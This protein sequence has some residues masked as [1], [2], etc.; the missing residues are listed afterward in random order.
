MV[1]PDDAAVGVSIVTVMWQV[2]FV[3]PNLR[4]E[5]AFEGD[6]IAI[7]PSTDT[8]VQNRARENQATSQLI[9]G[10]TD[11]FGNRVQVSVIVVRHDA[12]AIAKTLEALISF[13]N[14]FAIACI[15]NGWQWQIGNP[16][17]FL[18]LYSDFFDCYPWAPG[19][20]KGDEIVLIG[21]AL[22]SIRKAKNFSG[23]ISPDVPVMDAF[24]KANPDQAILAGLQARWR[25]RFGYSGRKEWQTTALF[26]SLAIAYQASALP[27][28]NSSTIFDYGTAI[29]LWVSAFEALLH[30]KS[31]KITLEAILKFF[32][33]SQWIDKSLTHRKFK[34][35][36]LSSS[37]KKTER[38]NRVKAFYVQLYKARNDFLHGNPVRV[39]KLLL[40]R[41]RKLVDLTKVAP[42]LYAV[43]LHCFLE[44][45]KQIKGKNLVVRA[46]RKVSQRS[47]LERALLG[48]TIPLQ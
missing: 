40:N 11:Q 42:L 33:K 6:F 22:E 44:T 32:D 29:S 30:P 45:V 13:R 8:R 36:Y 39:S 1:D 18:T 35:T 47:Q 14:A 34:I 46:I 23:Q 5:R 9:N 48:V 38:V 4:L 2:A 27:T 15:L 25:R 24:L 41:N 12:P 26:R 28:K 37:G 17:V 31:A 7:S 20:A 10:F 3:L 19:Q 16:N 21:P 43:A